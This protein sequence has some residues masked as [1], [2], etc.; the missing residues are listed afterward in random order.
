LGLVGQSHFYRSF[1]LQQHTLAAKSGIQS[2][3]NSP[4]N[5]I[6]FFIGDLLNEFTPF[7]YIQVTSTAGAYGTAI[8]VKLDVVVQSHLEEALV[9]CYP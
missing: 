5:E 1:P 8:M 3:V 4:V 9:R 7:F 2:G 6:F